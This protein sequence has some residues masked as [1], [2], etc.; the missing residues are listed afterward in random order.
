MSRNERR[1]TVYIPRHKVNKALETPTDA[2]LAQLEGRV[3]SVIENPPIALRQPL[4]VRTHKDPDSD[5]GVR[6][7]FIVMVVTLI[8]VIL[9]VAWFLVTR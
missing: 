4:G 9:A 8:L 5:A 3:F 1:G 7:I 6:N 2:E